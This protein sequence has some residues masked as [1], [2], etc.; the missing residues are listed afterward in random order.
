MVGLIATLVNVYTIQGVHWS[1]T[2]IITAAVIAYLTLF[3]MILYMIYMGW[4]EAVWK[5]H[6]AMNGNHISQ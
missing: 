5:E 2:A 1:V 6:C 3:A 4:T